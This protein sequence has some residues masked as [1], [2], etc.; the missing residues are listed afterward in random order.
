M[1]VMKFLSERCVVCS[2][3]CNTRVRFRRLYFCDAL[4]GGGRRECRTWLGMRTA[5]LNSLSSTSSSHSSSSNDGRSDAQYPLLVSQKTTNVARFKPTFA[6]NHSLLLVRKSCSIFPIRHFTDTF[7]VNVIMGSLLLI[8]LKIFPESG[9]NGEII[10]E[11][12]SIRKSY[13]G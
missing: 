8:F 12:V 5:L 1:R 13:W 7:N 9:T 4:D 2:G 10:P 3:N 11:S 6:P